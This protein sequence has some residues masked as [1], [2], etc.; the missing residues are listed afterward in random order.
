MSSFKK[1]LT[2]LYFFFKVN[3]K[4]EKKDVDIVKKNLNNKKS[5]WVV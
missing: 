5:G 3:L 2:L 1:R 4:L